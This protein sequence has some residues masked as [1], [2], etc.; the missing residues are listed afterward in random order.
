MHYHEV[1][2]ICGSK[3]KSGSIIGKLENMTDTRQVAVMY[4]FDFFVL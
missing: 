4:F 3:N 2:V 1:G